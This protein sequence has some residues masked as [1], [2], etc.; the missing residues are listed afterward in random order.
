MKQPEEYPSYEMDADEKC[1]VL[2]VV[3]EA[4]GRPYEVRLIGDRQNWV[5]CEVVGRSQP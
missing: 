4:L 1:V 2:M 3:S 5:S